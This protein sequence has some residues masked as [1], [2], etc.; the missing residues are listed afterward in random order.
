MDG[1]PHHNGQAF[2]YVFGFL[3]D[4]TKLANSGSDLTSSELVPPGSYTA[5]RRGIMPATS[6]VNGF[7]QNAMSV[8]S[9][10]YFDTP[11]TTSPVTYNAFVQS[12]DFNST[13]FINCA[14]QTTSIG[15]ESGTS[16]ISATEIGG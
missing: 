3:R 5:R 1:K 16:W 14:Q 6:S 11:A 13:L 4:G 12:Y 2:D 8:A 7:N 9:Y 15:S 10:T